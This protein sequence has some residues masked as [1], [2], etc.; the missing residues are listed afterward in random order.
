MCVST[1]PYSPSLVLNFELRRVRVVRPFRFP[2]A[3]KFVRPLHFLEPRPCFFFFHIRRVLPLVRVPGFR[4]VAVAS[5]NGP[6]VRGF[7]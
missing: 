2:V 6:G 4:G 1:L 5:A 3:Q 7:S